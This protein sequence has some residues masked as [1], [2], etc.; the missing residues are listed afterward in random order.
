MKNC[1]IINR[2]LGSYKLA[3]KM[4]YINN[5]WLG[6]SEV[7]ETPNKQSIRGGIR[8]ELMFNTTKLNVRLKRA[9]NR[10]TISQGNMRKKVRGMLKTINHTRRMKTPLRRLHID[11]LNLIIV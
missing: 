7:D 9:I 8:K 10:L 6:N 11:L 1:N 4:H 5:I 2:V 3:N